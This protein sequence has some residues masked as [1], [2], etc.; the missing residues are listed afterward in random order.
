MAAGPGSGATNSVGIVRFLADAG[1]GANGL[2]SSDGMAR[3]SKALALDRASLRT[4]SLS[5]RVDC[6][7]MVLSEDK[8]LSSVCSTLCQY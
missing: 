2:F 3:F 8:Y 1:G 5:S 4:L 6:F 7:L